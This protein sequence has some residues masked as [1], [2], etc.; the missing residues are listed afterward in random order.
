MIF[1]ELYGICGLYK[2][3]WLQEVGTGGNI[4]VSYYKYVIYAFYL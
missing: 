4:T 1:E 3:K 2:R